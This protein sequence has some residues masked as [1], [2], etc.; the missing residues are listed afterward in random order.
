MGTGALALGGLGCL[1]EKNSGKRPNIVVIMADDMSFS[2]I[3]CYGSEIKTPNLD[4]LAKEG[5]RFSQFYNYARCCPTRA[6]LMTGLHPHQAGIGHMAGGSPYSNTI[7]EA[8]DDDNYLGYL[9]DKCVTIP[10]VLKESGYQTMMTGKWH[11]GDDRPHWPIDRGFEKYFGLIQGA[12]NYFRPEPQKDLVL[13]EN[14]FE[15][16]DDF[17]TTDYFSKYAAH[18][19][20]EADKDSPFFLY[21]AYTAPHWPL[22]AWPEDIAKY[23][24][25]YLKGWDKL[26][27]ER[28]R[29]QLEMNLFPNNPEL[30][31]RN[32]EA[33]AWDDVENKEEWAHR[34]AVY[35]AMVDR[36][37]QGIGQ[38][39]ESLKKNGQFENTLILFL[40]DNGGCAEHYN[41]VKNVPAGP[42]N[43][44]TGYFLEWANASNTP[45]RLFK[46]WTHEGGISSPLIAHW[47]EGIS[48]RNTIN[49][50][51][52]GVLDFMPSFLDLAGADYPSLYEGK[53]IPKPEGESVAGVIK[54]DKK[55][56]HGT[57]FWAHEGNRAVRDGKW[58]LVAY[59][60]EA[61]QFGT[62]RGERIGDWELYDMENDRTELNN[63][64]K[65]HPEKARR[66]IAKWENF[67]SRVGVIDWEIINKR[68]GRM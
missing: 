21:T 34:M 27:T 18:F 6:A 5:M 30:S 36:M 42:A 35:A 44:D 1:R 16:P 56:E 51:V 7:N 62:A 20:E 52:C 46:H 38:I 49:H 50:S 13:N 41:P 54:Q 48:A 9:N 31:P 26:R 17:Y 14:P 10:E 4:G 55:Q 15:I 33:P 66:M 8:A 32:K 61:R 2:D 11:L 43:S 63:I 19:V 59:Y 53:A 60:N 24:D 29:R 3:G 45:F 65:E 12:S 22:H 68:A 37:D 25:Y 28:Y 57:M 40:S 67:A 58:K 39:I 23:K 47:P 64:I